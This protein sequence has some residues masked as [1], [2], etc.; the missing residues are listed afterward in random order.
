MKG[1]TFK[2]AVNILRLRYSFVRCD[3]FLLLMA[4]QLL[5]NMNYNQ[6][7]LFKGYESSLLAN[8]KEAL[9]L[10]VPL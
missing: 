7:T 3:V 5:E 2:R 10:P 8:E 6:A 9:K 1:Q 4:H